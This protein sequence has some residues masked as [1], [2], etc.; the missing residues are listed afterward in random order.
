MNSI[1]NEEESGPVTW[2]RTLREQVGSLRFRA[3]QIVVHASRV[4]QIEKTGKLRFDK[5]KG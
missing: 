1:A 4:V 3:V 2:L 5:A